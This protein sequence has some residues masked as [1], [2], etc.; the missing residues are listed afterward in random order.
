[1]QR[2]DDKVIFRIRAVDQ[3]FIIIWIL[4]YRPMIRD[5]DFLGFVIFLIGEMT[6]IVILTLNILPWNKMIVWKVKI[7]FRSSKK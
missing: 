6:Y 3:L 4:S 5:S 2:A 1:M 7:D